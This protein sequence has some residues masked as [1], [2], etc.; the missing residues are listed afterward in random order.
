MKPSTV[1]VPWFYWQPVPFRTHSAILS[2]YKAIQEEAT[3]LLY[4]KNV[5]CFN[6][7]DN[8]K[9]EAVLVSSISEQCNSI[10]NYKGKDWQEEGPQLLKDFEFAGF[11]NRIGARNAAS[12][13]AIQFCA[14]DRHVRSYQ[15]YVVGKLLE[16]HVPNVQSIMVFVYDMRLYKLFQINGAAS[17]W[18]S[19]NM[20][21]DFKQ[22]CRALTELVRVCPS[23]ED[24]DYI[25]S[26]YPD[27]V[28][29]LGSQDKSQYLSLQEAM[30]MVKGR[31]ERKNDQLRMNRENGS[32]GKGKDII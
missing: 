28:K 11:L 25:W 21:D 1:A 6:V 16:R 15:F 3:S 24:F 22:L 31:K 12:L 13:K 9:N 27:I 18:T 26:G 23:L 30:S 7:P 20:D 8:A 5:F 19:V 32:E 29:D 14:E 17:F 2:T 4:E 10:F